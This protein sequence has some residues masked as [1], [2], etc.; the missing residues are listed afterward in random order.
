MTSH[1]KW[2]TN[3]AEFREPTII[4][5]DD[6]TKLKGIGTGDVEL[7]VFDGKVWYQIILKNALYVPKMTFNLF[8]V[9]QMLNKGYVQTANANQSI[10]K[11]LDEKETVAIAKQD[12]NLN[13]MM[14]RREKFE[15]CLI[16]TSI[17]TW[18]E[19]LAHQNVKYVRNILKRSG[20][21]P[22]GT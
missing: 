21:N 12:G 10:F 7:E 9:T 19:R 15:N 18:H 22:Y 8:S 20:T 14:F 4:V 11:T 5:I 17:K 6:T 16:S 13:K 2:L 1:R 3:F